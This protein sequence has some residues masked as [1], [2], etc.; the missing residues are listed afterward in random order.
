MGY[1]YFVA[2]RT[3]NL[4]GKIVI[5]NN[6]IRDVVGMTA[7]ECYGVAYSK[8][9]FVTNDNGRI[10]ITVKIALKFGVSIDAVLESVRS[11]IKYDVEKFTGMIVECINIDVMGIC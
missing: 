11:A 7:S 9:G 1:T 3:S 10:S 6:A 5:T 8:S 2:F 4:Y